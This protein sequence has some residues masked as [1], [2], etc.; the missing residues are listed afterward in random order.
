MNILVAMNSKMFPLLQSCSDEYSV[1]LIPRISNEI[2]EL[3]KTRVKS[4][5]QTT[6]NLC[7]LDVG[8]ANGHLFLEAAKDL[9]SKYDNDE[10]EKIT[11]T[12]VAYECEK[13]MFSE[14]R[15]TTLPELRKLSIIQEVYASSDV[16]TETTSTS[17]PSTHFDLI[18]FAHNLYGY[19]NRHKLVQHAVE[20]LLDHN[21][22]GSRLILV[23]RKSMS[24]ND[25]WEDLMH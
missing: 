3:T 25:I 23:H 17:T 14:L 5:M 1:H 24:G 12:Y 18:L 15:D 22:S 21:Q 13:E 19:T 10:V 4:M 11:L 2:H 8:A 9:Q 6:L 7:I 20:N 16:F